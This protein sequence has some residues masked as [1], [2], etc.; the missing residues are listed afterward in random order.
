MRTSLFLFIASALTCGCGDNPK[1]KRQGSP[2]H[3]SVSVNGMVYNPSAFSTGVD[4]EVTGVGPDALQ[5]MPMVGTKQYS[6]AFAAPNGYYT[7]DRIRIRISK[8]ICTFNCEIFN[9]SMPVKLVTWQA[10]FE[11]TNAGTANVTLVV[12]P[13]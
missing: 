2:V 13:L 1:S 10:D 4:I 7:G 9:R 6:W 5:T 11:V 12:S 3:I 8:A